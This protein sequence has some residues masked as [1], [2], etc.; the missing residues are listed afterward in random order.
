MHLSAEWLSARG[1]RHPPAPCAPCALTA[2]PGS[3]V[4]LAELVKALGFLFGEMCLFSTWVLI[5]R[6]SSHFYFYYSKLRRH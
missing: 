1:R 6:F 3:R 4:P 2:A 5:F